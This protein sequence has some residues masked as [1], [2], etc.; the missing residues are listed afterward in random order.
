[1]LEAPDGAKP[2][3]RDARMRSGGSCETPINLGGKDGSASL[4]V[5]REHST[6]ARSGL[7]RGCSDPRPIS[8]RLA[9][10]PLLETYL[11]AQKLPDAEQ[12]K[13]QM[14]AMEAEIRGL[15]QT[16]QAVLDGQDFRRELSPELPRAL[17]QPN[18]SAPELQSGAALTP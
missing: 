11:H 9:L 17:Q 7:R 16:L 1:M 13:Q 12:V 18:G 8:I 14:Q 6:D 10:K 4:V 15:Q 3:A 5:D 2:L